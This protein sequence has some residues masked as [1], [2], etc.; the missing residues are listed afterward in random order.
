MYIIAFCYCILFSLLGVII[1]SISDS[2]FFG[3]CFYVK[4]FFNVIEH[5]LLAELNPNIQSN[6]IA[7]SIIKTTVLLHYD[8]KYIM[9]QTDIIFN[10][11]IFVRLIANGFTF[12]FSF[13]VV[14]MMVSEMYFNSSIL[15]IFLI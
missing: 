2:I 4:A 8:I 13:Y 12:V 10:Q 1:W 9:K 11:V 5:N 15:T 6:S 3:L 7:I 14:R